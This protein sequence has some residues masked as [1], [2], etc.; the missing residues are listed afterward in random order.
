[1][2]GL[3]FDALA[4]TV[5]AFVGIRYALAAICYDLGRAD[6]LRE[7]REKRNAF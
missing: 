6:R 7:D 2:T 4:L 5:I 3:G 1:M